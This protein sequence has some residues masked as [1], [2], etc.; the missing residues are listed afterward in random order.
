[1]PAQRPLIDPLPRHKSIADTIS[2][3]IGV[4]LFCVGLGWVPSPLSAW[5]DTNVEGMPLTVLRGLGITF[6]IVGLLD[7]LPE[8]V[9]LVLE[10]KKRR[11]FRDFFGR[12]IG[13]NGIKLVTAK[14]VVDTQF[15]K[16]LYCPNAPKEIRSTESVSGNTVNVMLKYAEGVESW[17]ANVDVRSAAYMYSLF[18]ANGIDVD[19]KTDSEVEAMVPHNPSTIAIGL[20]FNG[21]THHVLE[22]FAGQ[23]L[24]SV[25]WDN[26][27]VDPMLGETD[28]IMFGD[29][30][31]MPGR[32]GKDGRY[33]EYAVIVRVCSAGAKSTPHFIVAGRSADGTAVAGAFLAFEWE[34]LAK[35]YETK[36]QCF[37]RTSAAFIIHF[38]PLQGK[39]SPDRDLTG[40]LDTREFFPIFG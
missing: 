1:M 17:I 15:S 31:L 37:E 20:G 6:F 26:S 13:K 22:W 9:R 21:H 3:G 24:V 2:L 23:Q 25:A 29:Q 18:S 5:I 10:R 8:I 36:E 12:S 30:M 14:R 40:E 35:Q 39:P 19:F 38:R 28:Q 4:T 34:Q 16:Y 27:A 7:L 33:D 11:R 32:V